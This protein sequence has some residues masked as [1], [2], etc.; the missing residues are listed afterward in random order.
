MLTRAKSP[1]AA[2]FTLDNPYQ[3][4]DAISSNDGIGNRNINTLN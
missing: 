1:A 2:K 4:E 3:D